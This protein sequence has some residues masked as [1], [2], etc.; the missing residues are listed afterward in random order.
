MRKRWLMG[1][2]IGLLAALLAG[3]GAWAQESGGALF[4][5]RKT[6]R[7]LEI[8]KGILETTLSYA[9]RDARAESGRHPGDRDHFERF[10]GPNQ[11]DA[12]YLY[13]QGAVFTIPV[14]LMS[15]GIFGRPGGFDFFAADAEARAE[16]EEALAEQRD[17]LAEL[18]AERL[19]EEARAAG[20][21]DEEAKPK[22]LEKLKQKQAEMQAK[23]QKRAEALQA[24]MQQQQQKLEQE[25]AKLQ[26][27]LQKIK[28]QLVDALANHGDSLSQIRPTEYITIIIC[29]DDHTLGQAQILSVQRGTVVDYKAGRLTLEAFRKKVLDYTN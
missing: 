28:I 20:E 18:E 5:A 8:M 6:G 15:E 4:D 29:P 12:Y 9:A 1:I 16:M 2:V 25:K 10:F 19:D 3:L 7:E 23:M 17:Q 27:V 11:I 24:R 14:G 21:G 13:G 26:V 22:D